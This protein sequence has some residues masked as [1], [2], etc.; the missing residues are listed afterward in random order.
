MGVLAEEISPRLIPKAPGCRA[1]Q[2]LAEAQRKPGLDDDDRAA[3]EAAVS[4]EHYSVRAL[5]EVFKR[6][7]VA[8]GRDTFDKHRHHGDCTKSA[9]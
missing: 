1:M 9:Q 6:L 5:Q 8:V 4:S 7:G 2:V 3:L